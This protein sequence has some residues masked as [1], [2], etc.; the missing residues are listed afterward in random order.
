[1]Y[2]ALPGDAGVGADALL[3]GLRRWRGGEPDYC[4]RAGFR[5][6]Q[7]QGG[8]GAGDTWADYLEDS[9]S[10]IR[11]AALRAGAGTTGPRAARGRT[12][13][14]ARQHRPVGGA[15]RRA[16]DSGCRGEGTGTADGCAGSV[17]RSAIVLRQHVVG[18]G[19]VCV[20]ANNAAST[21]GTAWVCDVV[22]AG[23]NSGDDALP[24]GLVHRS[25]SVGGSLHVSCRS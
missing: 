13:G 11:H 1:M 8:D 17:A 18:D 16:V 10:R 23:V 19:D 5:A 3:L 22:W 4:A 21:P 15:S 2:A 9:R 14:G 12:N 25:T 7:L 20:A 24:W 6:G